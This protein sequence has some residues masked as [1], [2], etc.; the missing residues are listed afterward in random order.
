MPNECT[1][2]LLNVGESHTESME[3]PLVSFSRVAKATAIFSP[4]NKLGEG[5]F[6]AVYKVSEEFD[7][8]SVC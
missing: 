6:G 2:V 4:D 8:H 1:G 3:L 5:G 7:C